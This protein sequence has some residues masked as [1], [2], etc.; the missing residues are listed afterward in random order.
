MISVI[1]SAEV[2]CWFNFSPSPSFSLKCKHY[3]RLNCA[4]ADSLERFIQQ[5]SCKHFCSIYSDLEL[6]WLIL[7]PS[8]VN[9]K[10]NVTMLPHSVPLS[11]ATKAWCCLCGVRVLFIKGTGFHKTILQNPNAWTIR[12]VKWR[13][14][15]TFSYRVP[16]CMFQLIGV[17]DEQRLNANSLTSVY[18]F[19]QIHFL[20]KNGSDKG[21]HDPERNSI[22]I[23][24]NLLICLFS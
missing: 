15:H 12:W 17:S 23:F 18:Y 2:P 13:S 11:T 19:Q 22:D 14:D 21:L 4:N 5:K 8:N 6:I 24:Q 10:H 20:K 1:A 3:Q 7:L 9:F 16:P